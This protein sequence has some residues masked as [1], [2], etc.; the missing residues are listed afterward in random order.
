MA[1]LARR[2]IE[3]SIGVKPSKTIRALIEQIPEANW[4]T[5]ADYPDTGQAQDRCNPARGLSG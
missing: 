3:F 4:V 1:E 5:I 2:G